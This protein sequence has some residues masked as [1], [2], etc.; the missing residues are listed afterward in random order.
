MSIYIGDK[1]V[2]NAYLGG[3][4]IVEA[5][6]Y[7]P[8]IATGSLVLLLDTTNLDSYPGSGSVWKDLSGYDN[9][10]YI[11]NL[12][13]PFYTASSYGGYFYFPVEASPFIT[14]FDRVA[15][16]SHSV[17]LN[18]FDADFTAVMVGSIDQSLS[19]LG[20]R[21]FV[22]FFSKPDG[23]VSPSIS[24]LINRN[25]NDALGNYKKAAPLL[26]NV[27]LGNTTAN[28]FKNLGQFFVNYYVRE[29]GTVSVYDEDN[30]LLFTTSSAAAGAD[31]NNTGKLHIGRYNDTEDNYWF[32]GGK[33]AVFGL[34]DKAL[35]ESERSQ[36]SDYYKDKIGF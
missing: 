15:Y 29:S 3:V 7:N 10:G 35:S 16:V 31:G 17:S 6:L 36:T 27:N 30:T 25:E 33:I 23:N 11:D 1:L 8:S 4:Q 20:G 26:N 34:Y 32:Q 28:A 14:D 2:T 22:G 9:D 5:T 12:M 13:Q 21:D 24:Y 19:A 18:I